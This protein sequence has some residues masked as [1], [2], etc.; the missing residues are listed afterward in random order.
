MNK[1]SFI[2]RHDDFDFRLPMSEYVRIHEE[3]IKADL[4]ET[5]V[6]QF[7]QFNHVANFDPELCKYMQTASH[8]DLQLHGWQ[9]SMYSEMHYDFIVRDMAAAMHY[10]RKLFNIV[11]TIWFPP[12][13]CYSDEMEKA[14][15][16]LGLKINNESH[17]IFEFVRDV[18]IGTF[19]GESFYFHG[20][21]QQEM[22]HFDEMIRLAKE[23]VHAPKV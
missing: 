10:A 1:Q 21:N 4:V 20:W 16:T 2:I 7:A 9:H 11:P 8:W 15:Q 14:A 17:S 5:A 18:P 3:F 19:T 23:V 22:T 12:W 6:L 13:N